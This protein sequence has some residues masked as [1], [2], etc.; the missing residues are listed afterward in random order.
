MKVVFIGCGYLGHNL[1][2]GLIDKYDVTILGIDSPYVQ[3]SPWFRYADV[4][5][6]G[7]MINQ[8]LQDAIVIDTV[9]LVGNRTTSD[10]PDKLLRSIKYKYQDYH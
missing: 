5:D 6:M 8:D 1:S 10:N 9:S 3:Y 2:K 7:T 4:F